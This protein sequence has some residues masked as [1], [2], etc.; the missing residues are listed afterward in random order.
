MSDN[1]VPDG[2]ICRPCGMCSDGTIFDYGRLEPDEIARA[3][4]FGITV[5]EVDRPEGATPAIQ[6]PCPRHSLAGC[7]V[8]DRRFAVCRRFRCETLIALEAGEIDAG[9]GH[10][11]VHEAKNALAALRPH[12]LPG[13]TLPEARQRE[14]KTSAAGPEALFLFRLW[15]LDT[16]LDRWFRKSSARRRE[17]LA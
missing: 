1:D 4:E 9:E 15:A 3:Q 17:P 13:E 7:S 14:G 5:I 11:R 12:L 16:V 10:R 6:F 2:D 8:Y